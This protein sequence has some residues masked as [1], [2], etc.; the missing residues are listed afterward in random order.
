MPDGLYERDVLVWSEQQA[1]LLRRLA[2]GELLNAVI[3]WPN[4]I[5][6]IADLGRSE[7]H[8]C[9][10]LLEQ[11]LVH[12]LKLH[13]APGHLARHHWEAELLA[14][15]AGVRR[16]YAPSMDQRIDLPGLYDEALRQAGAALAD[17][18]VQP[19]WPGLCPYAV[20]D[21]LAHDAD[22]L[23]LVGRLSRPE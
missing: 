11:A 8:A 22:T 19:I 15:L 17:A 7:L 16:R 4:V 12:L 6:E 2:D 23:A 13:G 9:E 20:T 5:E 1:D 10:S 14:F 3:D 21:L 18:P